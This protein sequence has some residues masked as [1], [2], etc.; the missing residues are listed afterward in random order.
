LAVLLA[1]QP[2]AVGKNSGCRALEIGRS[3]NNVNAVAII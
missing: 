1:F 3:V 2:V